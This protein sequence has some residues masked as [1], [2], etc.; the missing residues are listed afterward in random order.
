MPADGAAARSLVLVSS[1][2]FWFAGGHHTTDNLSQLPTK[3]GRESQKQQAAVSLAYSRF[4]FIRKSFLAVA[5][6]SWSALP[7]RHFLCPGRSRSER[8][9]PALFL[10]QP[11]H[12]ISSVARTAVPSLT[13]L[14]AM[15]SLLVPRRPA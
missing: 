1:N 4:P 6:R 15:K 7:L 8:R 11:S 14:C 10:S 3:T 9:K 13:S 5:F 12:V 2:T